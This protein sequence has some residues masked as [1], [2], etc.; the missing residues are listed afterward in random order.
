MAIRIPI[1][2]PSLAGR[3]R[4]Y[5]LD[6]ID[7]NWISSRG[8][9]VEA[10]EQAFAGYTGCR[11]SAA[12]CNGTVAVHLALLALGIGAGDEVIVPTLTYIAPVNAVTYTGALPVFADSDA[13]SWQMDP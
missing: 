9:Y 5:V 12:V 2:Q 4:E 3:E 1:Y 7:S 11:Y 13:R 8:K 6:C 10:F